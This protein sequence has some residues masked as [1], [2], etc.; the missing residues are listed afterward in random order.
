MRWRIAIVVALL[1]A[2]SLAAGCAQDGTIAESGTDFEI[3]EGDLARFGRVGL[4][5][6]FSVLGVD[7]G[8]LVSGGPVKDGIPALTDPSMVGVEQARAE[9]S[10]ETRGILVEH[11]GETRFYPFSILVWHEIVNDSIGDLH[12]A[13]TF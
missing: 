3:T 11:D 6:D 1:W 9:Q 10:Q 12:F 7:P 8:M 5:T 4:A 2:S 13:A